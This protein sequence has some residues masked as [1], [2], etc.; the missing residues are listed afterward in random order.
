MNPDIAEFRQKCEE[1]YKGG[2]AHT[3][4]DLD[5]FFVHATPTQR[6]ELTG[7][8]NAVRREYHASVEKERMR[9]FKELRASTDPCT[10]QYKKIVG[11]LKQ[12]IEKHASDKK[13]GIGIFLVALYNVLRL[14][15]NYAHR[16]GWILDDI[17]I[18]ENGWV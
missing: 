7:V 4:K 11:V 9:L 8:Q 1:F 12:F 16:L 5:A 3:I 18:T 10:P 17:A 14:Q 6:A 13:P 15:R 2:S